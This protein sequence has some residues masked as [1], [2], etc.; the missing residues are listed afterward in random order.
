MCKRIRPICL[1]VDLTSAG[2]EW[3][4]VMQH[5]HFNILTWPRLLMSCSIGLAW[6]TASNRGTSVECPSFFPFSLFVPE[7]VPCESPT[8]PFRSS[9]PDECPLP[10]P[11]MSPAWRHTPR[12]P[13]RAR[14]RWIGKRGAVYSS[15]PAKVPF[16]G[17]GRPAGDDFRVQQPD[18]R[19]GRPRPEYYTIQNLPVA[20]AFD[21]TPH[22]QR[23]IRFLN[24]PSGIHYTNHHHSKCTRL[25]RCHRRT[26][27]QQSLSFPYLTS[28]EHPQ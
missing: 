8:A 3:R 2:H 26:T 16:A 20:V 23:D 5:R 17:G 9:H 18:D 4:A 14:A 15:A 24:T 10:G 21:V 13:V 22:T 1:L 25:T 27:S 7:L 28:R 12:G 11:M 19:R 6:H